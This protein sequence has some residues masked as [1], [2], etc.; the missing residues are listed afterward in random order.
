VA[1]ELAVRRV[2]LKAYK[3]QSE[4]APHLHGLQERV[5]VSIVQSHITETLISQ[6][7]PLF[8]LTINP[9][10]PPHVHTTWQKIYFII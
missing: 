2:E 6:I 1:R 9:N 7:K 8:W 3:V 5:K 10:G 4:E